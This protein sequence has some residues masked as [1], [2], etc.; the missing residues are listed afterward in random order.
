MHLLRL[1]AT[2]RRCLFCGAVIGCL[3]L[4]GCGAPKIVPADPAVSKQAMERALA[5]W[6]KGEQP[7]AL[8]ALSPPIT[9]V[10]VAW[11]GGSKLADYR[12]IGEP[13]DDGANL[14]YAVELVLADSPGVTSAE[15]VAYTV[16]TDPH[17]T[18]FRE[19]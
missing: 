10:D 14:H 2:G 1:A 3:L 15:Q 7:T 4:A 11:N 16:G 6:K 17:I 12:L 13:K 19:D 8:A 5:S 9:M 18:I